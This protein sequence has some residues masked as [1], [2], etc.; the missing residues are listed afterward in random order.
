MWGPLK[1]YR[2]MYSEDLG[3]PCAFLEVKVQKEKVC[4]HLS[5]CTLHCT[6][7]ANKTQHFS[8]PPTSTSWNLPDDNISC[9]KLTTLS[10]FCSELKLG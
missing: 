7:F 8:S 10:S 3:E 2:F 4:M 6:V 9:Q 5:D 1:A